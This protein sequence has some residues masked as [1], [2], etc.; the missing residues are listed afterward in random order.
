[1]RTT[2][3][4]PLMADISDILTGQ[5]ST[6]TK[7]YHIEAY[8]HQTAD[9]IGTPSALFLSDM[10]V[11][12]DYENNFGDYIEITMMMPL[13]TFMYD[14]YPYIDNAEVS[15]RV[16]KQQQVQG[17]TVYTKERYKCV[18]LADRNINIP[19]TLV[20]AASDLDITGLVPIRLQLVDRGLEVYRVKTTH[21]CYDSRISPTPITMKSVL[22]S[23]LVSEASKI[24]VERKPI[25]DRV[26]LEEPD[27]ADIIQSLIIPSGTKVI[28][29]PVWLQE[30][31]AGVYNG[32][33]GAY[34]QPYYTEKGE[35]YK[36][37][38]I[39]NLY[40]GFKYDDAEIKAI[41]YSPMTSSYSLADTTYINRNGILRTFC[42]HIDNI[43]LYSGVFFSNGTGYRSAQALAY[44]NKPVDITAKGPR[45]NKVGVNNEIVHV[46]R[47]DGNNYA[48]YEGVTS[49]NFKL[50]TNV[51]KNLGNPVTLSIPNI[52]PD[53]LT[54]GMAIKLV[55]EEKDGTIRNLYGKLIRAVYKYQ[56]ATGNMLMAH[57]KGGDEY[58]VNAVLDIHL[59]KGI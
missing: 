9:D 36:T 7:T 35:L 43:P 56:S 4:S 37:L 41:I 57:H 24:T 39:Y 55:H 42:K 11:I 45:F 50:A 2:Q 49:N 21:G 22:N 27:N 38:F 23:I 12:R 47:P 17:K 19:T 59:T 32:G 54:P 10:V 29:L 52:E 16:R 14:I 44:M 33:I 13:G 3:N 5:T 31:N 34:I 20:G 28:E 48:K 46:E 53:A 6:Y 26:N 15:L 30:Q 58:V 51:L 18:Y 8:F 40:N 25:I 1:M